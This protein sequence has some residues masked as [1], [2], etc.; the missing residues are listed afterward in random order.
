[1]YCHASDRVR[2]FRF[3]D[4]KG[5]K[6]AYQP[7]LRAM[8]TTTLLYGASSEGWCMWTPWSKLSTCANELTT[9]ALL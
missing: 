2:C 4:A 8:I 5:L 6:R 3:R 1:V 7:Q 9:A